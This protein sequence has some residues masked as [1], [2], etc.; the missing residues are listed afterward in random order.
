VSG[1]GAATHAAKNLLGSRVAVLDESDR[2][3]QSAYVTVEQAG[4]D[5]HAAPSVAAAL[6]AAEPEHPLLPDFRTIAQ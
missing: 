4:G 3:G 1:P 2:S 5:V 6:C